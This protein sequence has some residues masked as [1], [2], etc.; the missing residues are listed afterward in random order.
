MVVLVA[1]VTGFDAGV[2]DAITTA[3]NGAVIA[4]AVGVVIIAI[5]AGFTQLRDTITT[6]GQRTLTRTAIPIAFIAV[7]TCFKAFRSFSEI[8]AP[9][10]I[11]AL[12][13]RAIVPAGIAI[14]FVAII[15]GLVSFSVL[16]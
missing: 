15:T 7:I 14:G 4:A 3:G 16:R 1:I 8:D 6:G 10:A 9:D 13:C 11:A 5:I 12:C 2:D